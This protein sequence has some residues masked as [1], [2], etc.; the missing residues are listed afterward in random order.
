MSSGL[1]VA[2]LAIAAGVVPSGLGTLGAAGL[3]GAAGPKANVLLKATP[4]LPVSLNNSALANSMKVPI[5]KDVGIFQLGDASS[6]A[7]ITISYKLDNGTM[8]LNVDS[9][10]WAIITSTTGESGKTPKQVT[11]GD[12]MVSIEFKGPKIP[13]PIKVMMKVTPP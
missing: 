2:V 6:A 13:E 1:A 5:T 7:R 11:V 8:V 9:D 12:Q 4:S 10:P 3:S